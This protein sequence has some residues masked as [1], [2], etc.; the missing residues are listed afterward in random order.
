VL[1]LCTVPFIVPFAYSQPTTPV[2]PSPTPANTRPE[3]DINSPEV[4]SLREG[5]KSVSEGSNIL[6]T[7]GLAI[8]AGS[9]ITIVSTSYLRPFDRKIRL[10]YL[11]FIPGWIFVALSVYFGNH[12]ARRYI[13]GMIVVNKDTLRLIESRMLD[14]YGSQL[15][16][17]QTGLV[18]FS[19]WLFSFLLWWIFGHWSANTEKAK[20]G[21]E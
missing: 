17:L 16:L 14:D 12:I 9:I 19:L 13:A 20:S 21:G 15:T 8:I 11:L 18:F 6:L 10:I 5:F 2:T 4:R 1:A 7:W 3:S